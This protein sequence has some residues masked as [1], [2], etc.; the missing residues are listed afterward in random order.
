MTPLPI[1]SDRISPPGVMT[2]STLKVSR[3]TPGLSEQR[4]S[5]RSRGSIGI[6]LF[7]RYVLVP[8]SRASASRALPPGTKYDTSAMCTPTSK[9]PSDSRTSACNASSRSRAEGG[10]IVATR[11]RVKSRRFE[12][13]DSGIT[14][15]EDPLNLPPSDPSPPTS[16]TT[17]ASPFG[18]HASA[19]GEKSSAPATPCS[20]TSAA[21]SV[22]SDPA[23]PNDRVTAQCGHTWSTD[24]RVTRAQNRRALSS[25]AVFAP[26]PASSATS[27]GSFPGDIST[28]MSGSRG[29]V[30]CRRSAGIWP[31]G[32]RADGAASGS[33]KSRYPT[34]A[35]RRGDAS[36]T[37]TT[38][39]AGRR[40]VPPGP[41]DRAAAAS[42]ARGA[43]DAEENAEEAPSSAAKD[44]S[45]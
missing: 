9:F 20:A 4:F 12:R 42:A 16:F 3:S 2:H 36:V 35:A 43:E 8:R 28:D 10:S 24:H 14:Q 27:G 23:R 5:H 30:G 1:H 19:S 38:R 44:S 32:T 39:P 15:Q 17:S 25:F 18:R 26:P 29:S 6:T 21:V 40:G 22:S 33:A 34:T 11:T 31:G 41:P 37:A 13:S 45:S 7:T